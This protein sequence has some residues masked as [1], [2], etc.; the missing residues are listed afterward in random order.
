MKVIFKFEIG[1]RNFGLG[2]E[3]LDYK[4]D[5]KYCNPIMKDY[6]NLEFVNVEKKRIKDVKGKN[7]RKKRGDIF[8]FRIEKY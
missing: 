3:N 4:T 2:G 8:V 1:G 6:Q 7:C 5:S